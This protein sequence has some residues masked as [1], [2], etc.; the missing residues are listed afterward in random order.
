MIEN[1]SYDNICH[2]HLEYYCLKQIKWMADQSRLKII[3][4]EFEDTIK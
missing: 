3:D 1:K 2:E 4:V